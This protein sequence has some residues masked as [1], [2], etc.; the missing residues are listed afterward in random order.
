MATF[1]EFMTVDGFDGREGDDI[2]ED[3]ESIEDAL[4]DAG[5]VE[6][7][8]DFEDGSRWHNVE[9]RV[10]RIDAAGEERFYAMTR[11]VPATE[12]QEGGEFAWAFGRVFQ[13][14]KV[15]TVYE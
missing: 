15:V 1:E 11:D 8:R 9:T 14:Q 13:K 4:Y 5:A 6:V 7:H 3:F 2:N 12:M 10:Y